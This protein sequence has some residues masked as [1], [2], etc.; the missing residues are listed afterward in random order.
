MKITSITVSG[1]KLPLIRPFIVAYETYYDMPTLLVK[2]ETDAGITGFGEATPDQH[3]TGETWESTYSMLVHHLAPLVIGEDPFA[4]ERIHE[5]MAETVYG[6]PSAKAAIDLA[7]YDIMGKATGQPVYNL[8]GG[9]YHEVMPVP[10][11][12]SILEPS[13][14]AEEAAQALKDGYSTIKIKVGTNPS[15]DVERIRAVRKVIGDG[16]QLRVDANQGWKNRALSVWVLEQVKDCNIDWIEQPVVADDITALAE[17]R[18]QIHIPVMIDEGVH[19]DREMRE[20]IVKQAA[21]KLNIKL[22]KAGGIYPAL[23]LVAQAEMAGM[24]CQVGSMVESA[25][26]TAA[27]AHLSAAKKAIISNELVGPLMFAR[28]VAVFPYENKT[29]KLTDRPGLGLDVNEQAIAELTQMSTVISE[30]S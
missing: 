13:V 30:K 20:T 3:V 5:R 12:V 9:R 25:V 23:K 15:M 8:L 28:D 18:R 16:V 29:I 10:Y 21:D 11:V 22:M 2:V 1:I 27:G 17:I 24:E 19:G 26:A 14:M 4:I 6:S 7:C